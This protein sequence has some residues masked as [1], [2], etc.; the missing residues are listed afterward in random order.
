MAA[1]FKLWMANDISDENGFN[2]DTHTRIIARR[3]VDRV[4][5]ELSCLILSRNENIPLLMC[6]AAWVKNHICIL[7]IRLEVAC[8]ESYTQP[9][10]YHRFTLKLGIASAINLQAYAR[11]L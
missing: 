6:R 4:I 10:K 1:P 2:M 7:G 9:V 11:K 8:M 3:M 5:W